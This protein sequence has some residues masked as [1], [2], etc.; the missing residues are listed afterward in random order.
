MN[1]MKTETNSLDDGSEADA[2]ELRVENDVAEEEVPQVDPSESA[3]PA[4]DKQINHI[5]CGEV[6]APIACLILPYEEVQ[7]MI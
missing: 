2:S 6:L 1:D 3:E 5:S 7:K 4:P